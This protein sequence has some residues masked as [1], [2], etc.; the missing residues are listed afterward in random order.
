ML[1]ISEYIKYN[2]IAILHLF[3]FINCLNPSWISKGNLLATEGFPGS[4]FKYEVYLSKQNIYS[5]IFQ[6]NILDWRCMYTYKETEKKILFP[7][8]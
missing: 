8:C 6:T 5:H 3:S 1:Y 4:I 2:F 7:T